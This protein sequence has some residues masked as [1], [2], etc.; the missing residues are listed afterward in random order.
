[1]NKGGYE[2]PNEYI[3]HT[4]G[5][6]YGVDKPEEKLLDESYKNSLQLADEKEIDSIGFPAISTGAFGYPIKE[7]AEISLKAIKDKA[8]NLDKEEFIEVVEKDEKG[9]F[10]LLEDGKKI[11]ATYGH[12]YYKTG[13][14]IYLT[15]WV[16]PEYI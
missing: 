14:N 10:S 16:P 3:I 2:L 6:V 12:E 11:R 8:N 13:K 7:A 1:M 4:L 5:P 15:D 9:R